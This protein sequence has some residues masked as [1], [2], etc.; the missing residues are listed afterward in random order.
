MLL[1]Y[2]NVGGTERHVLLLSRGLQEAG[3]AVRVAL[4]D[5]PARDAFRD[6]GLPI[7]ALPA[8]S[9]WSMSSWIAAIRAE[10]AQGAELIH[11]HAAME[12]VWAA[13]LAAPAVP[14]V[15][16]AHGYHVELDYM[17]AGLMLNR[18]AEAVIAVSEPEQARLLRY[19]LSA[20]LTRVVPNGIDLEN[21]AGPAGTLKQELDI[22]DGCRLI[23]MVNRLDPFKGV[24]LMLKALPRLRERHPNVFLGIVG[25]GPERP[26]LERLSQELGMTHAVRW[27]GERADL[28]N[29]LRSYDCFVT[30]SRKEAFGMAALEAMAC[31]LPVLATDLPALRGLVRPGC[32]GELVA[33]EAGPE[34]W[35]E[36]LDGLLGDP[37]RMARYSAAARARAAG[38]SHRHMARETHDLYRT[39]ANA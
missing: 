33:L 30:P 4:P 2:G 31:G 3:V 1:P 24:D 10:A 8:P 14:R 21:L 11:V 39:M 12:L 38:F 7:L 25:N 28:G 9:V 36:A 5:G 15:F 6:A 18:T 17:K 34:A 26:R 32:E 37:D 27:L 19:G 20:A 22:P 16:T 29:V 23:G 13:K 35:T